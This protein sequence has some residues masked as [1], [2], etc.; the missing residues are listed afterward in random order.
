[1]N[2]MIQTTIRIDAKTYEKITKLAKLD[3]RSI[4]SEIC[5]IIEKHIEI[6]KSLQQ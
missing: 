6:R 2:Y 4:N 1:M 3:R 5:Y